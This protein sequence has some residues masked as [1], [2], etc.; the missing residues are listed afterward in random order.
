MAF[1]A[2]LQLN[3][4]ACRFATAIYY[5]KAE[6]FGLAVPMWE[7]LP[8][9]DRREYVQRAIDLLEEMRP[10]E[11]R[12]LDYFGLAAGL[13]RADAANVIGRIGPECPEGESR[14][15]I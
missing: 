6:A 8:V 5:A 15:D 1:K 9:E 14:A 2:D 7:A 12:S 11:R 10:A 3:A 13:A 4:T